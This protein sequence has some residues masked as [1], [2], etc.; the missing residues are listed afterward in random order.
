MKTMQNEIE[1][2]RKELALERKRTK[3][4]RSFNEALSEKNAKLVKQINRLQ[5]SYRR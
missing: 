5:D 3:N 4:L 1:Q 2:L